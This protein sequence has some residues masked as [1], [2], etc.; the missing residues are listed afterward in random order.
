[1]KKGEEEKGEKKG[2]KRKPLLS[3]GLYP[4]LRWH[5]LRLFYGC[6]IPLNWS[7]TAERV[8]FGQTLLRKQK[9]EFGRFK[10][11]LKLLY[12]GKRVIQTRE[13]VL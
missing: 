2:N 1:M 8:I 12:L 6:R 3:S 4:P 11:S 7:E 5:L 13:D 9:K 10:L